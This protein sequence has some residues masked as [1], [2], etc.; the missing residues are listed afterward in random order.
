MKAENI[1]ETQGGSRGASSV[2]LQGCVSLGV[3]DA[4]AQDFLALV[5]C[6]SGLVAVL[7]SRGHLGLHSV[8]DTMCRG[9]KTLIRSCGLVGLGLARMGS[10]SV[11]FVTL[12]T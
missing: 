6:P 1:F 9:A 2:S 3:L 7:P 8:E 5:V 4:S 10:I 12:S 11:L